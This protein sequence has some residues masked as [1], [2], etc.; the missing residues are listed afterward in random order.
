[1]SSLFK[2]ASS[3]GRLKNNNNIGSRG[4]HIGISMM[5]HINNIGQKEFKD[6]SMEKIWPMKLQSQ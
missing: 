2:D 4:K 5:R 6:I 1:M 3:M